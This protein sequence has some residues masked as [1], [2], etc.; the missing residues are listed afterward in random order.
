MYI[1]RRVCIN[2]SIEPK[3]KLRIHNTPF[4][5]RR[6]I[7]SATVSRCMVYKIIAMFVSVIFSLKRLTLLIHSCHF[8]GDLQRWTAILSLYSS[9]VRHDFTCPDFIYF[10]FFGFY[11]CVEMR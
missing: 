3:V 10:Y 1:P 4:P 8:G 11:L 2:Y 5:N 9:H 6:I 7:E